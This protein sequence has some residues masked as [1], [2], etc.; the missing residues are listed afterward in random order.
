MRQF[1]PLFRLVQLLL[2]VLA[3]QICL[4]TLTVLKLDGDFPRQYQIVTILSTLLM[5]LL[6][7]WYRVFYQFRTGGIW[8]D[9]QTLLKGWLG[10]LLALATLGFVTRTN[11]LFSREVF[12]SWVVLGALAQLLVHAGTGYVIRRLRGHGINPR[13]TLFVGDRRLAQDLA[14]RLLQ[15]RELGIE[16]L[17]LVATDPA[18]AADT[19]GGSLRCLGTFETL[20][21]VVRDHHADLVYVTLPL[22]QSPRI[23]EIMD[24]LVPLY[25]DVHWAPDISALELLNHGVYEVGSQPVF[26]LSDSPLDGPH[27]IVKWLEDMFLAWLMLVVMSPLLVAVALAVK[28]TSRGPV[29][30]KQ[31][32]AGLNGK[33]F[34]VYKFRSMRTHEELP[35]QLTQAVP[36]DSRLTPIG[37]FLRRTS[38]DELPQFINVLQGH[39]SIVGP[40]PHA[41]E[42]DTEFSRQLRAYMLRHRVKPGITG[43]AQVN[44]W[45]GQTDTHEKVRMRVKYDLYYI[46]NWSLVFDLLII[47]MTVRQVLVGDNAH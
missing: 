26:C 13:R 33:V 27:R 6:Y 24:V 11:T 25:V 28:L 5:L 17:G 45:R 31:K 36:G 47:A 10:V 35:G 21:D 1:I 3:V 32:R 43:W 2:A 44:G 30:F 19:N 37:A 16:A 20:R 46:N 23:S 9:A 12:L 29:L 15:N 4:Y 7:Q 8:G 14:S 18:S 34:K 42:H 40:R 22:K 38:L 41:L 39:M